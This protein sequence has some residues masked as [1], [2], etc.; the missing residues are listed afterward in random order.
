MEIKEPK[1]KYKGI[2]ARPSVYKNGDI[3]EH[4]T[5][6]VLRQAISFQKRIP[7]IIGPHPAGGR[8][9]PNDYIGHVVQTWNATQQRVDGEF[10][11][12]RE[13]W[14]KIPVDIQR[15][16][17][18]DEVVKLSTGYE[19][20]DVVEGFQRGRRYDHIALNVP[21]PMHEDVGVNVRMESEL[22]DNFR[23]EQEAQ[24]GEEKE[25]E[26]ETVETA[27]TTVTFTDE[28][29]KQLLEAIRPIVPEPPVVSETKV[30]E[31]TKEVQVEP[32]TPTPP[33]PRMEP[34]KVI[35]RG[36]APSEED[37]A[38]NDDTVA[39]SVQMLGEKAKK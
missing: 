37:Y 32:S 24:I 36:T 3:L 6:E 8:A 20:G 14:D 18:N 2:V 19:I 22:P 26:K 4:V 28:Q 25:P 21:N 7:L 15:Q 1:Q 35:P 30:E 16:L 10:L 17:T 13:R 9:N 33:E 38:T 12:F 27:P 39:V 34:E 29:F 11:F 23:I 31:A 5:A